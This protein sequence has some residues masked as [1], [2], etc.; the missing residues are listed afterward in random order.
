[1]SNTISEQCYDTV[2]GDNCVFKEKL[3]YDE[4]GYKVPSKLRPVSCDLLSVEPNLSVRKVTNVNT[5]DVISCL[6][7]PSLNHVTDKIK[8][9]EVDLFNLSEMNTKLPSKK[10][11]DEIS[12]NDSDSDS[13]KSDSSSYCVVNKKCDYRSQTMYNE[14][15]K[16]LERTKTGDMNNN[17]DTRY[18]YINRFKNKKIDGK[19]ERLIRDSGICNSKQIDVSIPKLIEPYQNNLNEFLALFDLQMYANS[20][21]NR[22]VTRLTV[23]RIFA[24]TN[25]YVFEKLNMTNPLHQKRLVMGIKR[26]KGEIEDENHSLV[27]LSWVLKWLTMV[28]LCKYANN[29][30]T[31]LIYGD[32]FITLTECDLAHMKINNYS[33]M[34]SIRYSILAMQL[35]NYNLD[36]YID[37]LNPRITDYNSLSECQK[38]KSLLLWTNNCV[39]NWI[40]TQCSLS[41]IYNFDNS[42]INGSFLLNE[43]NYTCKKFIEKVKPPITKKSMVEDIFHH[44]RQQNHNDCLNKF[45]IN[46][47]KAKTFE[48]SN[49]NLSYSGDAAKRIRLLNQYIFDDVVF[50][51]EDNNNDEFNQIKSKYHRSINCN[52]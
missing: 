14:S 20:D 4:S 29:F 24:N 34:Q 49:S 28:G 11:L 38:K 2:N 12:H 50:P 1:M 17:V 22:K 37:S 9:K 21:K 33:D 32:V 39:C 31:N 30:G 16:K 52:S 5:Q 23:S 51:N 10:F 43:K 6:D 44:L 19:M 7:I 13:I 15:R 41:Y 35:Y 8:C 45:E 26:L 36:K 48:Y 3:R 40:K 27:T 42:G 47:K 18:H 46:R 25:N